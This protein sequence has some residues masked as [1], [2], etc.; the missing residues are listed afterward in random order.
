MVEPINKYK[1][2]ETFMRLTA[3]SM[4]A[5][6][7]VLFFGNGAW[8]PSFYQPVYL[9]LT[10][11]SSGMLIIFSRYVLK[12]LDFERQESIIW[13]RLVITIALSL[14]VLGELYLYQLYKYGFQYDKLIHFTSS[15]LF[16]TVIASFYEKWHK[17]KQS[18]AVVIA[19]IIVVAG[20]LL[21]ELIE[22]SSDF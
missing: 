13:L 4:I 3:F 6:G 1:R 17:D 16:L 19:V 18:R 21:W 7:L 11:F 5:M 9:S 22:F 10:M 2:I 8:W 20:S 14:N 12:P 15:F